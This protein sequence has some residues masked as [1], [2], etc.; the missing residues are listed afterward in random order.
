MYK[1]KGWATSSTNISYG[2]SQNFLTD[3]S[4]QTAHPDQQSAQ[5]LPYMQFYLYHLSPLLTGWTFQLQ[6]KGSF[7]KLIG[8]LN[9]EGIG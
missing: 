3:R 5:G 4:G 6:F 8:C 7:K 9:V 1:Q 2:P